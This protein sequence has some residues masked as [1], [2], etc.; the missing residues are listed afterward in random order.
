MHEFNLFSRVGDLIA[1][2]RTLPELA[3][4]LLPEE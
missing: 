2:A 3:R 1:A 4:T